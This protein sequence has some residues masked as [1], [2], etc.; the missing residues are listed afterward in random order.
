LVKKK[1]RMEMSCCDINREQKFFR[2]R[3]CG[4][5]AG[6]IKFSGA[7]PICCDEPMQELVP[8]TVDASAEKHVPVVTVEGDKVTVTVGSVLHPSLPEHHIEWIYLQ[9]CCGGYRKCIEIGK[10]TRVTFTLAEGDCP[11]A[12]FEYCNLHGLWKK[13]INK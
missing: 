10:E 8:N 6:M 5:F 9:T 11:I 12:A 1:E 3:Y 4:N 7:L 13:D 2:C